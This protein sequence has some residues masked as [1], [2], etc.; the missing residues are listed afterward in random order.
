[1]MHQTPRATA[2]DSPR[3]RKNV[4]TLHNEAWL[5]EHY[6]EKKWTMGQLSSVCNCSTPTVKWALEKFGIPIRTISESLF[7]RTIGQGDRHTGDDSASKKRLRAHE[8]GQALKRDMVTAY[9]GCCACCGEKEIAFL[10]LDHVGGGGAKDRAESGGSANVYRR[11][12]R[13]GW[14]KE[15]YRVLCSNCNLATKLGRTCP[16]QLNKTQPE[17]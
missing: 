2:S 11:L 7:G 16:H 13:Q 5:R 6:V 8:S 14:P 4:D 9:G 1:M 3:P 17:T 10:T 12:K 15:G